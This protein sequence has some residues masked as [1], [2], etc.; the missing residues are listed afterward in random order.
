MKFLRITV[1]FL[2]LLSC[3]KIFADDIYLKSGKVIKNASI[4][5]STE[6]VYIVAYYPN[7]DIYE[8]S[9]KNIYKIVVN[10]I[11]SNTSTHLEDYKVPELKN[12]HN[13]SSLKDSLN[14]PCNDKLLKQLATRDSL[15]I[16]EMKIYLELK[17]LCLNSQNKKVYE[18]EKPQSGHLKLTKTTY[19]NLLLLPLGIIS[20]VISYKAFSDASDYND[21]MDLARTYNLPS[22]DLQDKKN[23]KIILGGVTGCLALVFTVLSVQTTEVE[24]S[25]DQVVLSYKYNF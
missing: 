5:D 24:A 12:E 1:L 4:K 11:E 22:G 13:Y 25:S 17:K 2:S 10:P 23:N 6:T 9:K 7:S 8:I 14:D 16:E 3:S 20:G 15:S 19:P 18:F 21:A